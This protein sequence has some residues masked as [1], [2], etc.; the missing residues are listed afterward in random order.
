MQYYVAA[1]ATE[2]YRPIVSQKWYRNK[3]TD[4]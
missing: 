2:Q 1:V 3:N 4:I